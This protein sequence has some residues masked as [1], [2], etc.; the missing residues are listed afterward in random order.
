ML[1]GIRKCRC[2]ETLMVLLV[3]YSAWVCPYEISF[4]DSSHPSVPLYIVDNIVDLF[5]AV[6][7][8]LTFF[9]AYI[10]ST[11]QLLVRDSKKIAK[12]LVFFCF[13]HF[14]LILFLVMDLMIE[15]IRYYYYFFY[16]KKLVFIYVTIYV[17]VY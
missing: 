7:I 2:W 16:K 4:L 15:L 10:D 9:V 1:V 8:I 5:F 14:R 17:W 12:R 13:F 6:D 11:T 3:S